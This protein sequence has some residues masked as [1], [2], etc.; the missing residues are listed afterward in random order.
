MR[1]CL[2]VRRN[3][4]KPFMV[5][6]NMV[7]LTSVQAAEMVGVS[8]STIWRACKSGRLSAD[9]NGKDFLIEVSELT[10]VFPVKPS[11]EVAPK[12]PETMQQEAPETGLVSELRRQI[13]RLEKQVES[14]EGDKG[15][16]RQERDRLLSLIEQ[17]AEQVRLLTDQR[18][19]VGWFARIFKLPSG[20]Q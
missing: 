13:G 19:K 17:Q 9:R 5:A 11:H 4:P 12:P 16:L 7:K 6:R 20:G 14:L 1:R 15:D 10:R 8:R 3:H 18:P 2:T